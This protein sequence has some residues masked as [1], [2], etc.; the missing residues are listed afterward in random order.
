MDSADVTCHFRIRT[1]RW[2]P[3][4]HS[5]TKNTRRRFAKT[6]IW[7]YANFRIRYRTLVALLG[8]PASWCPGMHLWYPHP[9]SCPDPG[10]CP[11]LTPVPSPLHI[12]ISAPA[13]PRLLPGPGSCSDPISCPDFRLLSDSRLL[14]RPQLL[15]LPRPRPLPR[16]QLLPRLLSPTPAP[17]PD[18]AES[19][20]GLGRAELRTES[21]RVKPRAGS[22]R[23]EDRAKP[24]RGPSRV[25]LK[26][27]SE[28]SPRG[29]ES[30]ARPRGFIIQLNSD[31]NRRSESRAW[32][33]SSRSNSPEA[34][35]TPHRFS[36]PRP[37]D[38]PTGTG[39]PTEQCPHL[40]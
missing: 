2:R 4:E 8:M 7:R 1:Y 12:S 10:S 40:P 5:R 33:E 6:N 17:V 26:S 24:G 35:L 27:G 13:P 38:R 19:D 28:P 36:L 11:I 16:P 39:G 37:T 18:R 32:P 3:D 25:G 22:S 30:H 14:P 29:A 31:R 34:R 21:S 23:A 9:G 15:L 20:R